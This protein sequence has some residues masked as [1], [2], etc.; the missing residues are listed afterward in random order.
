MNKLYNNRSKNQ[1]GFCI[2]FASIT[3]SPGPGRPKNLKN[4]LRAND[5]RNSGLRNIIII[6]SLYVWHS[7]VAAVTVANRESLTTTVPLHVDANETCFAHQ[8]NIASGGI[9]RVIIDNANANNSVYRTVPNETILVLA[10]KNW[11]EEH[12]WVAEF[13]NYYHWFQIEYLFVHINHLPFR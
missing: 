11:I 5:S 10:E 3:A 13:H 12:N 8:F 6:T 9:R 1:Y 7:Q 2:S 4:D